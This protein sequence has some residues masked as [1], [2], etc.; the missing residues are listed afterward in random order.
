MQGTSLQ[1][2]VEAASKACTRESEFPGLR[3]L[4]CE[5]CRVQV[6]SGGRGDSP[7]LWG[8]LNNP[9]SPLLLPL[10]SRPAITCQ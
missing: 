3:G 9:L 10:S 7:E 5:G 2:R 8:H 4:F 6:V 1:K